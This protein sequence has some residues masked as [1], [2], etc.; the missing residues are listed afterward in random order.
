MST[1][2]FLSGAENP[3]AGVAA[4]GLNLV[5][6]L[7]LISISLVLCAMVCVL[8]CLQPVAGRQMRSIRRLIGRRAAA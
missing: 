8:S 7:A 5:I 2:L 6:G 4:A 1:L 3:A